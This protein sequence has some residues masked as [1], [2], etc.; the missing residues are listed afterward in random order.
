MKVLNRKDLITLVSSI[1]YHDSYSLHDLEVLLN[2][3]GDDYF[4]VDGRWKKTTGN[5]E[6]AR[7]RTEEHHDSFR[8]DPYKSDIAAAYTTAINILAVEYLIKTDNRE[9][10]SRRVQQVYELTE[11]ELVILDIYFSLNR[12]DSSLGAMITQ[13]D[14]DDQREDL[15]YFLDHPKERM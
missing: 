5:E 15:L 7:I 3:F 4:I 10:Y 13:G 11:D 12:H 1:P 9:E 14:Y 2:Q 8:R 6:M